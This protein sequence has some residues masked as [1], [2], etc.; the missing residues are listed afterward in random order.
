MFD[1]SVQPSKR[2]LIQEISSIFN[3]WNI[4]LYVG[5]SINSLGKM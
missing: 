1:E 4:N 2:Q 5:F 3:S